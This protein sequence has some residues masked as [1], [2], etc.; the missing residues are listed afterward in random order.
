MKATI[1]R[2]PDM[3]IM[4]EWSGLSN[5]SQDLARKKEDLLKWF[6]SLNFKFY[7]LGGG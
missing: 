3:V 1:E 6:S 7:R 2:S 4:C 5:N